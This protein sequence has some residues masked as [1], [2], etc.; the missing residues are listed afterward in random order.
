MTEPNGG[1][2]GTPGPPS[3]RVSADF[4]TLQPS[5]QNARIFDM[6]SRILQATGEIMTGIGREG[7]ETREKIAELRGVTTD[8][9]QRVLDRNAS[10]Q[11]EVLN[12]DAI[13]AGLNADLVDSVATAALLDQEQTAIDADIARLKTVGIDV[14]PPAP[15]T[16]PTPPTT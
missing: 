9:L 10:L 7:L 15:P 6:T 1:G 13:I 12:R 14:T 2:E 3:I 11:Q 5:E 16:P 8:T 4:S